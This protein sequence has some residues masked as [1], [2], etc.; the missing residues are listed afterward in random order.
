MM[1][2]LILAVFHVG[3]HFWMLEN[4]HPKNEKQF[5]Q[6]KLYSLIAHAHY[7]T[8]FIYLAT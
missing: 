5:F 1:S 2:A 7:F 3:G 6:V 8:I 4:Q